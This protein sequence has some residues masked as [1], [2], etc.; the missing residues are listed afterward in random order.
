[1][2]MVYGWGSEWFLRYKAIYEVKGV[3]HAV[4]AILGFNR[5]SF[6][7]FMFL[8]CPDAPQQV[9][10]QSVIVFRRDVQNMNSQHF[11]PY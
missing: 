3:R 7:Y 6:R 9:S 4:A 5:L 2:Y 1:M 8:R 10:T 11:F